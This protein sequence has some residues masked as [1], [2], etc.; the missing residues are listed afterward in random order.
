MEIQSLR[1]TISEDDLNSLLRKHLPDD[2]PVEKLQV[3]LTPAGVVVT[4]VYPL[5]INVSFETQWELSAQQGN[6]AARL[7]NLRAL[8][9]PGNVF[10]SAVL[11]LVA[12]AAKKEP[13]LRIDKDTVLLDVDAALLKHGLPAR[14]NLT[15]VACAAGEIIVEAGMHTSG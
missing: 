3:R 6:V 15:R 8:G 4:G 10:K 9:V 11:K 12:D 5:F 14:T 7:A 1:L 13:W 2:A